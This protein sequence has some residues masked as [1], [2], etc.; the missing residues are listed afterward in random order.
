MPPRKF[1]LLR[2]NDGDPLPPTMKKPQ[3]GKKW[4]ERMSNTDWATDVERRSVVNKDQR[5]R[6]AAAKM[7]IA[8]ATVATAYSPPHCP[9]IVGT[10]GSVSSLT[11]LSPYSLATFQEGHGYTPLSRFS[12]SPS[13]G[14]YPDGDPHDEFNPNSYFTSPDPHR[15]SFSGNLNTFPPGRINLNG[16]SPAHRRIPVHHAGQ[17]CLSPSSSAYFGATGQDTRSVFGRMGGEDAMHDIINDVSMIDK[18]YT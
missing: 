7:K 8:A 16:S 17:G 18:E 12:P 10:Q 1:V 11:S 14:E 2:R 3:A 15:G 5:A 6:E 13:S 4:L 9:G